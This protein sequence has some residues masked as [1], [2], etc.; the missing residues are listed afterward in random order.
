MTKIKLEHIDNLRRGK[1]S[2]SKIWSRWIPHHLY[3]YEEAKYVRAL[4]YKYLEITTKDRLNLKNIWQKVCLAKW[5]DNYTLE[6]NTTTGTAKI[7]LDD[8]PQDSGDMKNMKQL[9][10]TYV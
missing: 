3:K 9:I 5:W 2:G 10:K 6:K 4:K 1:K 7:L 8:I